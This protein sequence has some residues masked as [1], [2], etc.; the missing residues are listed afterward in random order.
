MQKG[1][2]LIEL[3]VTIVVA[4]I[5]IAVGLP[6]YQR[7]RT[8]SEIENNSRLIYSYLQRV[9]L[10]ADQTNRQIVI[11]GGRQS[12]EYCLMAKLKSSSSSVDSCSSIDGLPFLKQKLSNNIGFSVNNIVLSPTGYEEQISFSGV[13]GNAESANLVLSSQNIDDINSRK[14][15]VSSVGRLRMCQVITDASGGASCIR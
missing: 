3:L 5:L 13:R 11:Y 15:I 14:I 12:S 8:E 1:L 2:T 4:V 10:I 7:M 6:S 9:K